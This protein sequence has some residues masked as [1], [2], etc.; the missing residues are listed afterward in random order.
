MDI[1][2][3]QIIEVAL[4]VKNAHSKEPEFGSAE[5]RNAV[6]EQFVQNLG[7]PFNHTEIGDFPDFNNPEVRELIGELNFKNRE[8]LDNIM[9]DNFVE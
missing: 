9:H 3:K 2:R 6:L 1:D 8:L 5:F 7:L 4:Y